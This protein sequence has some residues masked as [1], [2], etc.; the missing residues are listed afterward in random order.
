MEKTTSVRIKATRNGFLSGGQAFSMREERNVSGLFR[1][2]YSE[3]GKME[4]ENDIRCG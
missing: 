2:M 1:R 4:E 3:R